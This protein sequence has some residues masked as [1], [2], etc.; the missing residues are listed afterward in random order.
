MRLQPYLNRILFNI[1]MEMKK[2]TTGKESNF[3]DNSDEINAKDRIN[4]TCDKK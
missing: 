4:K 2:E 1:E 3:I